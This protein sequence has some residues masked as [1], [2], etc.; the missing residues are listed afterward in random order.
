MAQLPYVIMRHSA[1]SPAAVTSHFH[2]KRLGSG[3]NAALIP[4][5]AVNAQSKML[6]R[7]HLRPT[8]AASQLTRAAARPQIQRFLPQRPHQQQHAG[9]GLQHQLQ[10]LPQRQQQRAAFH[11]DPHAN[12]YGSPYGRPPFRSRLKD[13]FI[14]AGGVVALVVGFFAYELWDI[15]RARNSLQD[16]LR[17]ELRELRDWNLDVARRFALAR[18]DGDHLALRRLTFELARRAHANSAE[19]SAL[20]RIIASQEQQQQRREG[21]GYD[22]DD[23]G[24][25]EGGGVLATN[26]AEVGTLPGL[27]F[28]DPRS[29]RELVA[30]EDT[31]MFLLKEPLE[32]RIVACHVAVNV[33]AAEVY[34]GMADPVPPP[35]ADKLGELLRRV[36]D[37]VRAWRRQDRL[38]EDDAGEVDLMVNLTLRDQTW[39][40]DWANGH[41]DSLS[42]LSTIGRATPVMRVEV[43]V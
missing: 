37:Q 17:A 39:S 7:I 33:E 28:D 3:L 43:D 32:D 30:A 1:A 19:N 38:L 36:D 20:D 18:R 21:A 31:L 29:G 6:Q 8:A 14:G 40:F 9:S 22:D 11:Y 16:E 23:E 2:S 10:L 35:E 26:V 41:F 25:D 5:R 42:G 12:N 13:M 34:R 24:Y 15:G 27:P 4:G